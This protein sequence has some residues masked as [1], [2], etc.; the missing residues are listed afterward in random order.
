MPKA[1]FEAEWEHLGSYY[2]DET[3]TSEYG[4]HNLFNLRANYDHSDDVSFFARIMNL[5]DR[6]YSTYTSNQVGDPDISYRPGNPM[7]GTV[8]IKVSML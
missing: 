1:S 3:N 6:R 5:T 7:T 4:G 8:G 2:T